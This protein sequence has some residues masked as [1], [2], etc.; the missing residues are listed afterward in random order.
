MGLFQRLHLSDFGSHVFGGELA[1][2]YVW[3]FI[4]TSVFLVLEPV[5]A[6]VTEEWTALHNSHGVS[7]VISLCVPGL[8]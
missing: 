8:L 7:L 3:M 2:L 4:H 5:Q 6:A 1:L